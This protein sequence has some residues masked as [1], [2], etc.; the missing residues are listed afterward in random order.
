MR[1]LHA[2]LAIL[3]PFLLVSCGEQS[4]VPV[5]EDTAAPTATLNDSSQPPNAW[6]SPPEDVLQVM[7]APQLPSVWTAPTG[8]NLFLADPI[9]YPSLAELAAPMHKL[10]G[11]RVNPATNGRSSQRGSSPSATSDQLQSAKRSCITV[12]SL[13][14]T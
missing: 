2:I 9:L 6:Q 10:A 14:R 4:V 13:Q 1:R 3:I 5:T 11:M 8:E 12:A 7:H